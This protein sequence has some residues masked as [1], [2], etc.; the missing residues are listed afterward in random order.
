MIMQNRMKI[1]YFL[2]LGNTDNTLYSMK[3]QLNPGLNCKRLLREKFLAGM[4]CIGNIPGSRDPCQVL[5]LIL[6]ASRLRSFFSVFVSVTCHPSS[7]VW[8]LQFV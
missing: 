6:F 5:F 7:R 3:I 4:F 8:D 1:S 2:C